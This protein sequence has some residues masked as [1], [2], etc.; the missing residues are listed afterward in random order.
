MADADVVQFCLQHLQ[1]MFPNL[2]KQWVLASHVWRARYSQPIV[3]RRYG[4]L[5][6]SV[7][8]PLPGFYLSSMAQVYPED[9]GTNYAIREGRAA[10]TRVAE[11]L[12]LTPDHAAFVP[13]EP[14]PSR[15][16]R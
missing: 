1:R 4:S 9:R 6:P 14:R 12:R 8:T 15:Q 7:E 5:I 2:T 11:A 10:G 3:V 16:A 13:L